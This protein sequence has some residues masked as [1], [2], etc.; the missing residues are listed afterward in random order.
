MTSQVPSRLVPWNGIQEDRTA[1]GKKTSGAR[2]KAPCLCQARDG[3]SFQALNA[4]VLNIDSNCFNF[5]E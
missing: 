1:V 2:R 3:Q 4:Y 5:L